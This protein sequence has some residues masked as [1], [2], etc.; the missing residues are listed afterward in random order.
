MQLGVERAVGVMGDDRRDHFSRAPVEI[1]AVAPHPR[2]RQ[3]LGLLERLGHGF[4]PPLSDPFVT[5]DPEI[6]PLETVVQRSDL[7]ILCTPHSAYKDA[8]LKGKPVADVWG[9]LKNANVIY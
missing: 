7:L 8:D 9:F 5:T 6:L 2:R 4:L 3:G 1:L